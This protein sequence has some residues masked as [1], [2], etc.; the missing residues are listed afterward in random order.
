MSIGGKVSYAMELEFQ[1]VMSCKWVVR[2]EPGCSGR[3][4]STA[5]GCNW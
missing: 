2:I 4:A 3:T 1:T 5:S